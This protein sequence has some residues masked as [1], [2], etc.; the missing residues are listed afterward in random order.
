M[1][2]CRPDSVSP[3][4]ESAR[5][6]T[7][8]AV[9]P[10]PASGRPPRSRTLT[11]PSQRKTRSGVA[12]AFA[13]VP[14]LEPGDVVEVR[15]RDLEDGRVLERG[16]AV[17][18]PGPKVE[19]RP[20]GDDLLV[21]RLLADVAELEPRAAALDVPALVLLPVELERER[22]ALAHEQDLPHVRVGVRPDQLPAPRLLDLPRLEC[23]PVEGAVVRRVEHHASCRCGRHSGCASMN[24]A[25]RRRSFGVFTVSQT[26]SWR[27]ACSLRS[28]ASCGNVDCSWS[29]FSGRSASASSPRT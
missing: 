4:R 1:S 9:S 18:R 5:T 3:G 6:T 22:L 21:K 8:Y 26:P 12:G 23:E 10:P 20:G 16:D 25:A 28:P 27:C 13:S 29:P 7:R 19:A 11:Q 17:H 14:V 24:S 2:A 15:R